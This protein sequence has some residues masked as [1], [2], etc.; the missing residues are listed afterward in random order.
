M[1]SA[2]VACAGR[3]LASGASPPPVFSDRCGVLWGS[4]DSPT[5]GSPIPV[6]SQSIPVSSAQPIAALVS[7]DQSSVLSHDLARAL[8]AL[9][10]RYFKAADPEPRPSRDRN[11]ILGIQDRRQESW[12]SK[13]APAKASV[14]KMQSEYC[15]CKSPR[16]EAASNHGL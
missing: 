7:S 9:A 4:E 10:V 13:F 12:G 15:V 8:T 3:L 5:S 1:A 11:P 16:P 6:T 14:P 2:C